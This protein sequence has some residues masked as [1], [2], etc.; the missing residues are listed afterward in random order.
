MSAMLGRV[1]DNYRG[2]VETCQQRAIELEISRSEIDRLSGLADGYSAKLL[3]NTDDEKRRRMWPLSLE[4]MLRVLGLRILL[5]EDQAA[6]A[7]TLALRTPVDASNQRMGNRNARA[8]QLS[9]V[10]PVEPVDLDEIAKIAAAPH[11]EQPPVSRAHLR[12]IQGKTRGSKY[13]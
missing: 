3:G 2:L 9:T 11:S 10:E 6:T 12:V 13:G 4:A 7:R 1:I 5:I 8:K